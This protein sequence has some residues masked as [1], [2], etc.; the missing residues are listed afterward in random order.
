LDNSLKP[1][2]D[3]VEKSRY[4][5]DFALT[6]TLGHPCIETRKYRPRSRRLGKAGR[7]REE[8]YR[9]PILLGGLAPDEPASSIRA[10]IADALGSKDIGLMS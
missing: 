9:S 3:C 6:E 4:R 2:E 5:R 1:I 7:G 10:V 8:T